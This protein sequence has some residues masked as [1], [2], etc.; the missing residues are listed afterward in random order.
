MVNKKAEIIRVYLPPDTNCLLSVADHCL[1]SRH[2]VNVIVAGKQPSLNYLAPEEAILHCT[3]GIGIWEWA[4]NDDGDPDVVMACCG[5]IPT[6]ETLAA[7]DILRQRAS[8]AADPRGQ[9]GRPDA[10]P[11]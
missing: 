11:A 10:P 2:Y 3:R 8:H 1:R 4:S 6:L 9:R 7:V 5:D